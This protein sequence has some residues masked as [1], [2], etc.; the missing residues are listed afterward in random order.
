MLESSGFWAIREGQKSQMRCSI[1]STLS[2]ERTGQPSLAATARGVSGTATN[3]PRASEDGDYLHG[4]GAK[5]EQNRRSLWAGGE[6]EGRNLASRRHPRRISGSLSPVS[7]ALDS[8][9]MR[10]EY[11]ICEPRRLLQI[12]FDGQ[13]LW[14]HLHCALED[15][16]RRA[17]LRL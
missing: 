8:P 1:L 17:R 4:V 11:R 15:L 13:S 14:Q 6:N 9:R 7:R 2:E 5:W 16:P 3:L 12:L 10:A